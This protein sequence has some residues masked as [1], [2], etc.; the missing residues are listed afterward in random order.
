MLIGSTAAYKDVSNDDYHNSDPI[1][2]S[3]IKTYIES[4]FKYQAM[5]LSENR[6]TQKQS[7]DMKFGSAF[8]TYI[9]E[10]DKFSSEYV[11]EPEKQKPPP[12]LLLKNVG[13]PLFEI[14]KAEIAKV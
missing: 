7:D 5:Y 10:N 13:R 4:P 12:K 6:P 2:R 14:N 3:R 9:L 1:S 11:I 8:H